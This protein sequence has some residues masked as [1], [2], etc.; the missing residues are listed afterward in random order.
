LSRRGRTP[1]RIRSI[2]DLW[3]LDAGDVPLRPADLSHLPEAARRYL[4]HAI[5]PGTPLATTVRLTMHGEI[6]LR[7]WMPFQAEQVIRAERGMI[8]KA[9]VGSGLGQIRGSDRLVDGRGAM[10]W[11]ILGLIPVVRGSGS[12]IARAGAG[13][14]AAELIWLPSAL[15]A[16]GVFWSGFHPSRAQA[17]L[18]VQ[19]HP[20]SLNL[21]VGERGELSSMSLAR[22]G[23]PDGGGF[24]P[25]DFGGFSE[26][27]STFGGFTLPSRLRVG[28]Y[29]GSDRFYSEGEFFRVT[30]DRAEYR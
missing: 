18:H 16:Q 21:S 9:R 22:W 11:R 24:R 29:F 4:E 3:S 23:N 10:S 12:D 7:Q 19:G 20:V 17:S 6:K 1:K 30:I 25:V 8:W 14:V 13:R 28:W 5:A 27:E 26:G 15:L 2:E